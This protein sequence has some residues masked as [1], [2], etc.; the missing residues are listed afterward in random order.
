ML[1][2]Y[3]EDLIDSERTKRV[4]DSL[5]QTL[6]IK[7]SIKNQ[8]RPEQFSAAELTSMSMDQSR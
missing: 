1:I 8:G 2:G 6:R 7:F 5:K 3:V 4:I